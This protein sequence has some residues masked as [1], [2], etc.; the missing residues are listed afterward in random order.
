MEE[1]Y[2][3]ICIPAYKRTGYLNRLLHSISIQTFRNYE[4]VITDDS[5]GD[6]LK[7]LLEEYRHAFPYLQYHKNEKQL[8]TPENWNA[9]VSRARGIWVKLMHDDDWFNGSDSLQKF[10]EAASANSVTFIFS[11]YTNVTEVSG[12]QIT[13]SPSGWRLKQLSKQ[14]MTLLSRNIIGPPSTTLYKRADSQKYDAGMKWLVDVDFYMRVMKTATPFFLKNNLIFVG[15]G[16]EQ[17]TASVHGVKEIE[18]PEHGHLLKKEGIG[19]LKNILV[20]DYWWRLFRNFHIKRSGDLLSY[21][22]KDL[23]HPV[24]V[25]MLKWQNNIPARLLKIGVLSKVFMFLHYLANR[26]K[27]S[28]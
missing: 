2:I 17:V 4:V 13:V 26:N 19:P 23:V 18:L 5:P 12:S 24:F 28:V 22:E 20:Y 9:A 16:D 11:A 15:V 21:W 1:I 7:Q 25:S 27:L 3:S 8:G 6:E 14:P 10:A